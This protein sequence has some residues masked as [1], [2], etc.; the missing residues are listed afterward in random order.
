MEIRIFT[1]VNIS[2]SWRFGIHVC[3]ILFAAPIRESVSFS[4]AFSLLQLKVSLRTYRQ[5]VIFLHS[6]RQS[7]VRN[8]ARCWRKCRFAHRCLDNS[9]GV[10]P[11]IIKEDGRISYD[12]RFC[13]LTQT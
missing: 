11:A 6:E 13:K 7:D 5:S 12:T 1:G 8:N 10:T 3:A 2:E 4:S 9:K